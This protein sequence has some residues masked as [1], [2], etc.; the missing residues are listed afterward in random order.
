[1]CTIAYSDVLTAD[2]ERALISVTAA[3]RF[4][5]FVPLNFL[6]KAKRQQVYRKSIVQYVVN[7]FRSAS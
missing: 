4:C 7:S 6:D 5:Q 2:A 1:M 3:D